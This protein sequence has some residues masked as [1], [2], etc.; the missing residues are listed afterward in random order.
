M[1]PAAEESLRVLRTT[2]NLSWYVVP[3]LIFVI[4]I[5]VTEAERKNWSAFY[6]GICCWAGELIWEQ[7]NALILHF[8]GYAPLW[9]TPGQSAFVIYTGLNIEIEAFFAVAGVIIVKSLPEDRN[10]KILGI[11]NRIFLPVMWGLISVFVETALNHAGMLVWDYWWWSFPHLYL[12]VI[13]YVTPWFAITRAHDR[14]S[15]AAKRR[16]AAILPVTAIITHVILANMLGW[17]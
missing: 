16:W 7:F 3:L 2:E 11:N 10:L 4:Y 13:V 15:I 12:V 6:L 14:L 8:T 5:Y 9:C 1:T 17:I